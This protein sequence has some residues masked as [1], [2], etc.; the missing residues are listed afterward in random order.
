MLICCRPEVSDFFS[1]RV[2]VTLSEFVKS[3]KYCRVVV[4]ET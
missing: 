2:R 3:M 1:Q 4:S